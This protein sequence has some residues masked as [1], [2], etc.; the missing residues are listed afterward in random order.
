MSKCISFK[1]RTKSKN[2]Q[3]T[4]YYYCTKL[5]KEINY[6]VCRDCDL[7]EYK[8]NN[9]QIKKT[10]QNKCRPQQ[11]TADLKRKSNK[12]AK[13]ERNRSSLFSNIKNKCMFCGSSYNLTW[14]EIFRGRN[15]QNSMKYKLCLRMCLN[16]HEKYQEDE[17]F[18]N[19]WHKKGQTI[20][21]DVYPDLDFLEI[22]KRNYL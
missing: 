5:R 18:N 1:I 2:K 3:R 16:C 22:F 8:L 12:L 9:N 21:N 17:K 7:K 19:E 11:T 13:L 4:I 15:R 20:F 14:H 6:D 10:L